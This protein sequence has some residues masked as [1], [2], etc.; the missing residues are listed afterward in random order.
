[1]E[2]V[3]LI[4]DD[5]YCQEMGRF[6]KNKGEKLNQIVTEY[7]QILQEIRD[8]AIMEGEIAT[9]LSQYIDCCKQLEGQIRVLS[10]TIDGTITR[11]LLSVDEADDYL[12]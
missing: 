7:V 8:S 6:F 10:T 3:Q 12:F 2:E 9:V 4:V 5:Q 11:F 1:M